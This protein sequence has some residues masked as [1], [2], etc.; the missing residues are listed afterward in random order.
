MRE[1]PSRKETPWHARFAVRLTIWTIMIVGS[2]VAKPEI[3]IRAVTV[4]GAF[5]PPNGTRVWATQQSA[6]RFQFVVD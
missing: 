4:A 5:V 6:T 3:I 1:R 2:A